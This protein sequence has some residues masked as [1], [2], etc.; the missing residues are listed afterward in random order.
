MIYQI[1]FETLSAILVDFVD[2]QP[3]FL[4]LRMVGD[5]STVNAIWARLSAKE[6]RGQS[7]SSMV[8]IS[9]TGQKSTEYV[10]AQKGVTYKTLRTRLPNGMIDL[11]MIHPQL[12]VAEDNDQG[13][14]LLTYEIELPAAFFDRFNRTLAIPLKPEW[15]EW[16]W[17]LG[18]QEQSFTTIVAKPVYEGGQRVE[19]QVYESVAV[20]P[21]CPKDGLG[22]AQVYRIYCAGHYQE[23][24]LQII[25]Q[26][27]KLTISLQPQLDQHNWPCY[28]SDD[29]QIR[30]RDQAWHLFQDDEEVIS[31]PELDRLLIEAR[32]QLGLSLSIPETTTHIDQGGR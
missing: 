13:F 31:H 26:Q 15:A 21:I 20:T 1:N 9:L 24:W 17:S 6:Y 12:T 10:S 23:A 29:W 14:Y 3:G 5:E 27:C 32:M 25:R 30:Q 19:K 4:Y 22:T 7:Y 8:R 11:A 16:L 2:S 28:I 18:Q